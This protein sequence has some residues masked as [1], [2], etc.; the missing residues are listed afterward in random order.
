MILE[1]VAIVLIFL[2]VL[3]SAILLIPFR[4]VLYATFSPETTKANVALSWVGLTLWRN[5][6]SSKPKK[7]KEKK[8]QKKQPSPGSALSNF[9]LFRESLPAFMIIGRS[10]RRAFNI[11]RMD[12]RFAFG[13]GDPAETAM[14]AGYLWSI[15][16]IVNLIPR[17]SIAFQPVFETE[18]LNGTL[19][20]E[21]KIRALP[22]VIGFI[23]AY[24]KKPFRQFIKQA[25]AR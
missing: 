11:R 17:V 22:L 10:A 3:V 19:N 18:E 7:P 9:S 5:K 16:W 25:R 12:L 21:V 4:V 13:S 15:L 14:L 6:P 1:I 8:P 2:I 20:I 23:H 24:T